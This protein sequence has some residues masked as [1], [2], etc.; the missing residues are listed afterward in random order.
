MYVYTLYWKASRWNNWHKIQLFCVQETRAAPVA[1]IILNIT[2]TKV[3]ISRSD[4]IQT[5]KVNIDSIWWLEVHTSSPL[6]VQENP[7]PTCPPQLLCPA[8]RPADQTDWRGINMWNTC[9][10][11]SDLC[12]AFSQLASTS[13]G[14]KHADRKH[15][16]EAWRLFLVHDVRNQLR[17][18]CHYCTLVNVWLQ[19]QNWSALTN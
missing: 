17:V 12:L 15:Q 13:C 19:L 14:F 16:P 4:S 1:L 8:V 18:Q 11:A 7:R 10:G 6:Q 2:E 9:W 3:S 5:F